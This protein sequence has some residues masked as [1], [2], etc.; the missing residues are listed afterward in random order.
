MKRRPPGAAPGSG[1]VYKEK[2]ILYAVLGVMNSTLVE[3]T[4]EIQ[5]IP[6]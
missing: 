1:K 6:A 4:E 5:T 2:L 3:K